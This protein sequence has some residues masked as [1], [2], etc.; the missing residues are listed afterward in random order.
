MRKEI[1]LKTSLLR[2]HTANKNSSLFSKS[3]A[4][5]NAWAGPEG[6]EGTGRLVEGQA[7]QLLL[8]PGA[9][10]LLPSRSWM[11]LLAAPNRDHIF[12]DGLFSAQQMSTTSIN[13]ELTWNQTCWNSHIPF[14]VLWAG[15]KGPLHFLDFTLCGPVSHHV[16]RG[17]ACSLFK[18]RITPLIQPHS[19]M[20]V[21]NAGLVRPVAF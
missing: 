6:R 12:S 14:P 15:W 13:T 4:P 19:Q 17:S 20:Q 7:L 11:S 16:P 9:L 18:Y 5:R 1:F 8:L 2:K 3:T 10:C 21:Q